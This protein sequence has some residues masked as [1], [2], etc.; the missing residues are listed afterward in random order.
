MKTQT[1]RD[2]A[3]ERLRELLQHGDTVYTVLRHVSR[4]GMSRVI[5]LYVIKDNRPVWLSGH[6]GHALGYSRD[7]TWS[8]IRV[9]GGGMDM[10]FDVVYNL[11]SSLFEGDGY[12]LKHDW[13]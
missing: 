4:S 13:M 5:D 1:E 12:A 2:E 9:N 7:K 3:R 11:S 6:V 10:G 8:G